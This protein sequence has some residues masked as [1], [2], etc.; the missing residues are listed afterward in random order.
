MKKSFR[1]VTLTALCIATFAP[2]AFAVQAKAQTLHTSIMVGGLNKII[3]IVPTI[4]KQ[5]GYFDAEGLQV[6]VLDEPAG[7]DAET[8]MLT[9]QV[10]GTVGFYDHNLDLQGKGKST[11]SVVQ[12]DWVPGE[13]ELVSK[14]NVDTIK[15]PADF[16]GKNLG[17]TSIGSSTYFLSQYL[18]VKAGLQLSDI[19][20]I[21][22]GAGD[23]FIAAINTGKID[24]GMTTDPT[25][26]RMIKTGD[27]S[28]LLDLRTAESTRAILGGTYPAACIYMQT[29]WVNSHKDIVQKLANAFVKALRWMHVHTAEDIAAIVPPDFY[30]GNKDL[31]IA[32]LTANL[33]IFTPDGTMPKDGPP[34]VLSVLS[35]FNTNVKDKNIDVSKTYTTEF[36]DIANA[37]LGPIP[38][39]AATMSMPMA[40]MAATASK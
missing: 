16:K 37:A 1:A 2:A 10:D 5:L 20:P 31:Y 23:T 38:T 11:E 24:A 22:V 15:S 26:A 3:Y 21:A 9:G 32:A 17:V 35:Q 18:A 34:T 36:V 29:A 33:G 25:I 4:A 7:A 40:T 19:T 8:A 30:A 12:F 39:M 14:K 28:I 27:A 13:A 6:D